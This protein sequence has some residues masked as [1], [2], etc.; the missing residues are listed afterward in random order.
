MRAPLLLPSALLLLLA[1]SA[2]GDVVRLKNGGRLEGKVVSQNDKEVVIET[3]VGRQTI[4]RGDVEGI[5][6]GRTSRDEYEEKLKLVD[7]QSLLDLA[8]LA[9]FCRKKSLSRELR[10]VYRMILRLDE[11]N[12]EAREGLGYVK[13]EGEWVL[14]ARMKELEDQKRK[15]EE[16]ERKKTAKEKPK[17]SLPTAGVGS[18]EAAIAENAEVDK[19]ESEA[20]KDFFGGTAPTVLSSRNFSIK[21]QV[22]PEKGREL[23]DLLEKAYAELN[24][25][26]SIPAEFQMYKAGPGKRLH[27]LFVNDKATF[28]DLLPWV[29]SK[30][31]KLDPNFRK[32]VQESGRMAAEGGAPIAVLVQREGGLEGDCLHMLGQTYIE[33]WRGNVP[34]WLSEG[35]AFWVSTTRLGRNTAYCMTLTEYGKGSVAE[36]D[37]DTAYAV[38]VREMAKDGTYRPFRELMVR[39]LN[40]LDYQDLA[41]S[42]ATVRYIVEGH[43]EEFLKFF[44]AY[45]AN[46]QEKTLKDAF[47][48]SPEEFE[49]GWKEWVLKNLEAETKK[50]KEK[51]GKDVPKKPEPKKKGS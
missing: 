34:A 50:G 15:K 26:F 18:L 24:A 22:P 25:K 8:D 39:G 44:K 6:L 51:K 47:G 35:F 42:W 40:L 7:K 21:G 33:A 48:V 29:E 20:L 11:D 13:V 36:K 14:K 37:L 1:G 4:P 3:D 5:D 46:D 23:L 17:A 19:A 43:G 45:R 16:E 38:L 2:F 41:Q 12:E 30:Y 31:R 28:N 10:D 9:D 32:M 27:F 49:A